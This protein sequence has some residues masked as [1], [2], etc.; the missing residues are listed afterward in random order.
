M[1]GFLI[2]TVVMSFT[3]G[4]NTIMAM[5]E[6]QQH[7]FRKAIPFNLG[8]FMGLIIVGGVAA[9]FATIFQQYASVIRGLKLIGSAYLLYLAY[10]MLRAKP[11]QTTTRLKR[12]VLAG[13]LLQTT[14]I[15]VYLYFITGL[16]AFGYAGLWGQQPMKYLLMILIGSIGTFAW[17][18]VGKVLQRY[19]VA[20]YRLF[21]TLVALLLLFS[22]Y[23][24]WR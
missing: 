2:F 18:F 17:T 1:S 6:G 15:K 20:H 16:S 12:P 23:D 5:G 22:A 9:F 11:D 19:Y 10:E 7:G 8:I 13:A 3:P 4:P 24:I 14:N 21:N